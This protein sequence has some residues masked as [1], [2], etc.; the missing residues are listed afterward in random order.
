VT[1]ARRFIDSSLASYASQLGRLAISL[2]TRMLLARLIIPEGHGVYEL[3]LRVVTIAAAVRDLGLPYH[4][5]RDRERPYGT[6]LAFIVASSALLT[7]I[8]ILG[9]P[10]AAHLDPELPAVLRVFAVWILLDGLVV[11]PRVYFERELR[12]GRLVLPEILRGLVTGIVAIALAARGAGAWSFIWGDLVAAAIFAALVWRRAWGRMPLR[13]QLGR[14]GDLLARSRYLFLIWI[15]FQLVTYIDVFIVGAFHDAGA[16]GQYSRAYWIAFLTALIVFPRALVPALVEYRDEPRRFVAAFRVGTVLL[17]SCQVIAGYFLFWNADQVVRILLG[18]DPRWH[19]AVALLRILCFV[20]FVHVFTDLGGE[21]LKVRSEDRT[22][23]IVVA[24][25]LASLVG[26]GILFTRLWGPAGMAAANFL[27][28]GNLVMAW[29][30]AAI[31]AAE[32][33]GLLE[34][35]AVVYLAPLPLFVVAA[36]VSEAGTWQRFAASAA[37]AAL[38]AAA[39]VWRFRSP[40]LSFLRDGGEPGQE[41]AAEHVPDR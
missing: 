1:T 4:L 32:L 30:M 40:F 41:R 22:W 6:V 9:A 24:L 19:P 21:V 13:P 31:F 34:D 5:M 35:L 18:P 36:L 16:V 29:R 37:A 7:V 27:L 17:M 15:A 3:A 33:R 38:A 2:A 14:I 25:N 39:M 8:V 23:L 28:A 26:F 11:V 12:I 20:P 10:L